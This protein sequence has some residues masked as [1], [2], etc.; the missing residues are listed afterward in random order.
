MS[1]PRHGPWSDWHPM[2]R[3]TDYPLPPIPAARRT[4][5]CRL[6][7]LVA[8]PTGALSSLAACGGGSSGNSVPT[9]S[10]NPPAPVPVPIPPSSPPVPSAVVSRLLAG[11]ATVPLTVG[12]SPVTVTQG[13]PGSTS[14]SF[15]PDAQWFPPLPESDTRNLATI[16]QVYGFQRGLWFLDPGNS[17]GGSTVLPASLNHQAATR[18]SAGP[19]AIHFTHTGQAFEVLV[20]GVLSCATLI[21]DGQYLATDQF[22]PMNITAN[23]SVLPN[24][25]CLLKIDF[26]SS[27][28]RDVSFYAQASP[29]IC[30][31]VVAAGDRVLPFERSAAPSF[32]A[33]TDSYGGAPSEHW[34]LGG[35][36]YEAAMQLGIPNVDLDSIGGT[37]YAPNSTN[38]DTLNAGNA[39]PA[40]LPH[41]V[42]D[43][44]DLFVVAGSLNDNDAR[45][46]PPYAS[47]ADA[48]AG[49]TAAVTTCFTQA[50]AALPN[51]VLAAI[52]PWQPPANLP[53][54]ATEQQKADI[55]RQALAV[56]AA[57]WIW[58]D[59]INGGWTNSS[60]A[61]SA[62]SSTDGPWQTTANAA[63]YLSS[64]NIH[65]NEAGC[66][67]LGTRLAAALRAGLLAL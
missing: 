19:V 2:H 47:G 6:F 57:P 64:D 43:Q 27:A 25:S 4:I 44:P 56:V 38:S 65:P 5:L 54:S 13:A 18:N 3:P 11:L 30:A 28:T 45:A 59:N 36:F 55:I 35:L 24:R 37:G 67:Y 31:L 40:R 9:P 22:D 42:D 17:I 23:G 15:G 50:R 34:G 39:F 49:F 12:G 20:C 58:I 1:T 21:V 66:L 46:Q 63:P 14:S 8:A 7:A 29:G 61:S 60:G 48:L 26:G 51:A 16:P 53:T 41:I 62:P 10:P 32:A 52:G 33:I